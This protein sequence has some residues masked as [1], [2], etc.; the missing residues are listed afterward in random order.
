MKNKSFLGLA[1]G[2]VF[3]FFGASSGA[4]AFEKDGITPD[5]M[6]NGKDSAGAAMIYMAGI[7]N[8]GPIAVG[9]GPS[10]TLKD[11]FNMIYPMATAKGD[12]EMDA[13]AICYEGTEPVA[14]FECING[15]CTQLKLK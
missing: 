11:C 15:T 1:A 6:K 4:F 13:R 10:G 5:T 7:N 3:A 9:L 12:M 2:L 8:G 14:G